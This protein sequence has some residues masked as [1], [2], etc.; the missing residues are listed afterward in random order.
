MSE[1]E[2]EKESEREMVFFQVKGDT[3]MATLHNASEP[4]FLVQAL[5][6]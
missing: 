1:K 3:N 6:L 4:Y 2:G 5:P